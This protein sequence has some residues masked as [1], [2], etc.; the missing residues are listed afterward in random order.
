[1]VGVSMVLE[2]RFRGLSFLELRSVGMCMDK[3]KGYWSDHTPNV[4]IRS[5]YLK[6]FQ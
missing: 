2:G 3:K 6:I 1:M 4:D 5:R